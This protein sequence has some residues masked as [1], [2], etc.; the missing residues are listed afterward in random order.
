MS[1][2]PSRK[3]VRFSSSEKISLDDGGEGPRKRPR[4]ERFAQDEDDEIDD[5]VN[6]EDDDQGLPSESVFGQRQ[7]KSGALNVKDRTLTMI[8]RMTQI[9]TTKRVSWPKGRM[10]TMMMM[11]FP[12]SPST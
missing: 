10:V 4:T 11:I 3:S 12:S 2:K 8:R 9:L 1:S 6:D 7:T 5:W